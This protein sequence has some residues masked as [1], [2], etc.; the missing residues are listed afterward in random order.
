MVRS[1]F[2][3]V[4][5]VLPS[6]LV[7]GKKVWLD[8]H[9]S[10]SSSPADLGGDKDSVVRAASGDNTNTD[11][12]TSVSAVYYIGPVIVGNQTFQTIYDTGS[13]LLWIPGPGCTATCQ[14]HEKFTGKFTS[15][16]EQF[17]IQYGSGSAQGEL[18]YAPVTLADASLSSFKIGLLEDNTFSD[19][20]NSPYDGLVGLAWPALSSEFNVPSLVP[21]MYSA[22]EI[23]NNLF[24]MY[25]APNGTGGELNLGEIDESLYSGNLTWLPLVQKSWWTVNLNSVIVGYNASVANG[26]GKQTTII[27]SGTS[28]IIG[29]N[30]DIIDLMDQ[31]QS[32]SGVPV[33]F[34]RSSQLYSVPCSQIEKLPSVSFVLSGS[35]GKSSAFLIPPNMYILQS[36]SSDPSVCP[37]TFQGAGDMSGMSQWILG[38]PFLRV[39]Y[40]VYDYENGRVGLASSLSGTGFVTPQGDD[41]FSSSN[42]NP[43]SVTASLVLLLSLLL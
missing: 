18:V 7:S 24:S 31:I 30:S 28:L 1:S 26:S 33:R 35:D 2:Y 29:P 22:G 9:V 43:R 39:F 12:L 36:L 23:P 38:D 5:V 10:S 32:S 15:T 25:F 19:F 14:G 6:V 27:D 17:F 4:L 3:C 8:K 16:N 41:S 20:S 40:S 13:N 11:Q 37:L 21:A 34:H 42:L